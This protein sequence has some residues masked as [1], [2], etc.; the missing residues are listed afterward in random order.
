[1]VIITLLLTDMTTVFATDIKVEPLTYRPEVYSQMLGKGMDVDW[2]KTKDGSSFYNIQTVKDF[3]AAGISHV[4]IRV[5]DNAT[6][7][8]L[9]SLEQQVDDCIKIGIIP[10]IAFQADSFKN[11]PSEAEMKKVVE[12]WSIVSKRYKN[13]SNL[14]SFDLLIEATDELN[15]SSEPINKLYEACVTE[16]RKSNPTRIIFISPRLRS[17]PAYLSELKLPTK[18]NGYIMAEWHFYASGPSKTNVTKQWTTG[19]EKEK[20]I[21]LNKIQVA[22]D[23][24]KKTGIKTW[25][26]A[27]MPGNYNDENNYSIKEQMGFATFVTKSLEESKIP[28]AINSDTK[29]YDRENNRW[30]ENMIPVFDSIFHLN[31]V[32]KL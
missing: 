17:D 1:M 16:I 8:L 27:W 19:T 9:D 12:W 25:V 3:K 31:E 24:Q 7:A 5:S 2:S 10:I 21:I 23:W 15:K 20:M 32:N 26:G 30:I 14:L 6:E 22:L 29:F 11:N 4:R 28:F 13:K 18:H